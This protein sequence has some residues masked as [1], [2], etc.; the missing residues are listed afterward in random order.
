MIRYQIQILSVLLLFSPPIFG[1]VI[2]QSQ[3]S[4]GRWLER[5]NPFRPVPWTE[6]IERA[7]IVYDAQ[8]QRTVLKIF[9][10]AKKFGNKLTGTQWKT[11]LDRGHEHLV[12]TYR[13]KFESGFDFVKGGKL[14]GF[15]GGHRPGHPNSVVSGGYK[16]NGKDGWS[17]RIMWRPGGKIVQ[18]LYHPDQLGKYGDNL[19]WLIDG[20]PAVFVPGQ[21]HTVR[22]EIRM[23]SPGRNDGILRSWLDGAQVLDRNDIRFRDI[24]KIEI[25]ALC[26]STFF[27]GDTQS[28]ATTKDEYTYF[29]SFS[30][31]EL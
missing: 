6:G 11:Y 19:P 29:D 25:D 16:P 3:F 13:V 12:L 27:G 4:P 30:V 15:S 2:F 22:T 5:F 31:E 23:N 28:W 10:P 7:S 18:Y 9:Y 1:K 17:A 14:P 8:L 24:S 20:N 26:F 21:W